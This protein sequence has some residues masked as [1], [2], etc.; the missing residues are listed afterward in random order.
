VDDEM[1]G[2]LVT[3]GDSIDLAA[4]IRRL[5]ED[6]DLRASMGMAARARIERDFDLTTNARA[7]LD[8]IDGADATRPATIQQPGRL[9]QRPDAN[10]AARPTT[11]DPP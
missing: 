9:G 2:L 1:S 3:P 6:P 8:R 5:V 4:A 11:G 7:I 10:L